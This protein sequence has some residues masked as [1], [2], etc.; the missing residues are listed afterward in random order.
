MECHE[1][2]LIHFIVVYKNEKYEISLEYITRINSIYFTNNFLHL[3]NYNNV[4]Y[5]FSFWKKNV[6]FFVCIVLETRRCRH[7]LQKDLFSLLRTKVERVKHLISDYGDGW[8]II[9]V[10]KKISCHCGFVTVFACG[11]N[12]SWSVK[13]VTLF[14]V[15][16]PAIQIVWF[17]FHVSNRNLITG[18]WMVM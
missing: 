8:Y 1:L 3:S 12:N 2:I 4:S 17:F 16:L 11:I 7:A 6:Y 15:W 5:S 10:Y 18:V 14:P 13:T 9:V